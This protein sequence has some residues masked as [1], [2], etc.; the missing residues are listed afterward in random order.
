MRL[1]SFT[2]IALY[3]WILLHSLIRRAGRLDLSTI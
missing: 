2:G 3:T 1:N